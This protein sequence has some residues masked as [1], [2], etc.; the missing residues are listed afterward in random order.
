[1]KKL[2][3]L[4]FMF[5]YSSFA[6][7]TEKFKVLINGQE[8]E[9]EAVKGQI[10]LEI[11]EL[12]KDEVISRLKASGYDKIEKIYK[13]FYIA[14]GKKDISFN[15]S[16]KILSA[17]GF[18]IYPNRVFKLF[19]VPNDPYFSK[20][21]YLNK[22]QATMAWD[23]E[24]YKT[25]VTV[26]VVDSGIDSTHPD[27]SEILY[28]TQIVISENDFGVNISTENKPS[29]N[30][31]E[32]HGTL[33][34]GIIGAIRNNLKGISGIAVSSSSSGITGVKIYSYD[35][36]RGDFLTEA[37]LIGALS[38]ILNNLINDSYGKIVINMS[39]GGEGECY[40]PLQTVVT[41]VYN[42]GAIIVAA[43]GNEGGPVGTPANCLNVVPVS[44]T[45]ENDELAYFSNYGSPMLNGVSAPGTNIYTTLVGGV[46][47]DTVS[48]DPI[49]GTSFSSPITAAVLA[50]VW[51]K[52]PQLKNYEVIN[53]VKKTAKDLGDEGPDKKYGWGRVDMYKALS[54][55]ESDL[56]E[57]GISDDFVAWP[58]P[59]YI[60]KHGF[61]KFSV[62]NTAIY[63][64]DKLLIYDFSG[65]FVAYAAKD[66]V[67]G[68]I[69]DGK[70]SSGL[71]VAPG[72]YV[73]YYKSDKGHFKT[74]FLLFR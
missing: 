24:E 65:S 68:F 5:G 34:S 43:A 8:I 26:V 32:S 16:F 15:S 17:S 3:F 63:P 54:Y 11:N 55:L 73:A 14:S 56:S 57:K 6:I 46:Y 19:N 39:L 52:R 30:Q 70:N 2:I 20:Q 29:F 51:G 60:S 38:H 1:M 53:I 12:N 22:I 40:Q 21:Y 18:K 36:F 49:S 58:N 31:S 27:I 13:N 67:K 7:E 47:G 37:G 41:D 23:F 59:F 48:G 42:S 44:A 71:Y 66:G 4:L 62:K 74:K 9:I 10:I 45:D 33:V 35:V 72:V 64:D 25:T 69:W 61:I 50:A 28:S